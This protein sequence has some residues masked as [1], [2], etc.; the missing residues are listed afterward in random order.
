MNSEQRLAVFISLMEI[1]S[2]DRGY[3][4]RVRNTA[5]DTALLANRVGILR[6][7]MQVGLEDRPEPNSLRDWQRFVSDNLEF[8]LGVAIGAVVA[9]S[10]TDGAADPMEPP[11][12]EAWKETTGLPWFGF[13]CR[14][15]LRWGTV[16]PFVAFVLSQGLAGTRERAAARR[17][18]FD[19]WLEDNY[20]G[21]SADDRIDPQLFL[22]WQRSLPVS[23]PD[24][25]DNLPSIVL[26][27]GS[28][29]QR[30]TYNVMPLQ[31][32]GYV[33]WIDPSGFELARSTGTV[34]EGPLA[35]LC[36]YE[37]RVEGA[38]SSVRRAYFGRIN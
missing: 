17:G 2:G 10:W 11:S 19:T 29:G 9:Q 1:V 21:L 37:M 22:E 8:R 5:T 33:S 34:T 28:T 30:G 31:Q 4:F 18:E 12:L 7:W 15:L 20:D 16:E 6:W 38:Q 24:A 25:E 14:E 26:R 35:H 36:D 13:W 32:D 3:G 23:T 27:T